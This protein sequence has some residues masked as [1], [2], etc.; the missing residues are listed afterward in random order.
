MSTCLLK[1]HLPET[2]CPQGPGI[3]STCLLDFNFFP[4]TQNS[5]DQPA[6]SIPSSLHPVPTEAREGALTNPDPESPDLILSFLL[7]GVQNCPDLSAFLVHH[8]NFLYG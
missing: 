5:Q 6:Q 4:S 1:D 3:C 8:M 2:T 7:R